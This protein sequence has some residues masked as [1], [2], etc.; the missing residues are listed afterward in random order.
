M[1]M[2]KTAFTL[3]TLCGCFILFLG[4]CKK[5]AGPIITEADEPKPIVSFS[6]D[7]S[8]EADPFTFSFKGEAK[9]YKQL[10]W[11]FG[12]DSTAT[13]LT[14]THTY[15]KTGTFKVTLRAQNSLGY[16]AVQEGKIVI[17]AQN[18][19]NFKA[20]PQA[21]GTLLLA[22]DMKTEV[23]S[24]TWY[25]GTSIK[26]T[27]ISTNATAS[28]PQLA[29][30]AFTNITL[31]IKTAKGTEVSST[32]IVSNNGVL[33]DVTSD[34][35]TLAV[36]TDGNGG[37]FATEGSLKAVDGNSATK[38]YISS[39]YNSSYWMQ[40]QPKKP[41]IVNAYMIMSANDVVDRDPKDWNLQGSLDG[42][43]WVQ[44]DKRTGVTSDVRFE[45]R[46]FFFP[47]TVA[48]SYYRLNVT[49]VRGGSQMQLAEW[50][51]MRT[52]L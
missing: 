40:Q 3:A 44:L 30:G 49:A 41:E 20:D 8:T 26:T 27:P 43:T 5:D 25:A 24:Y 35:S 33:R 17:N 51:L 16:W 39:G 46:I 12:D 45:T 50:R 22:G 1:K 9:N 36:S 38:M 4:A 52:P 7:P 32:R 31:K 37:P 10:I 11:S 34:G 47:N 2:K 48:Y 28:I 6:I 23:L 42:A 15:L 18:V 13:T 19:L 21:D 29:V 14:P